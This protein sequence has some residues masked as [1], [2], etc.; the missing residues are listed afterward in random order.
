MYSFSS[1]SSRTLV[2]SILS[3]ESSSSSC[4]MAN[5]LAG[6]RA[7]CTVLIQQ[8]LQLVCFLHLVNTPSIRR[9]LRETPEVKSEM[10]SHLLDTNDLS[11]ESD[12]AVDMFLHDPEPFVDS[13]LPKAPAIQDIV[14]L[15]KDPWIPESRPAYHY[16]VS[17]SVVEKSLRVVRLLDASVRNDWYCRLRLC[18]SDDI[19]VL[20]PRA[21]LH[22]CTAMYRESS[23]TVL[24]ANSQDLL[25]NVVIEQE[26]LAYLH[27]HRQSRRP[28][29]SGRDCV[30]KR[31]ILQ[32]RGP[33]P[34]FHDFW[35]GASHV[36][37]DS[38]DSRFRQNL[39]RL[40]HCIGPSSKH[41]EI[42]WMLNR[43][44][45]QHPKRLRIAELDAERRNHL[46]VDHGCTIVP[47]QNAKG[48]IAISRKRRKKGTPI[49]VQRSYVHSVPPLFNSKRIRK[50]SSV[51]FGSCTHFACKPGTTTPDSPPV[52]ITLASVSYTHLRAHE[53]V[54]DLV[55]RLLLEKKK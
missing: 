51:R 52:R 22:S 28:H 16:V 36:D 7:Q 15:L 35:L 55:C 6:T 30:D 17:S 12:L 14:D 33:G 29:D 11:F 2:I 13:G 37:I 41:L 40:C 45:H 47:A 19:P 42:D 3:S 18:C 8:L 48:T 27:R 21:S 53:T 5:L 23:H 50:P 49:E 24:L 1:S 10:L 25:G 54:L 31:E 39:S 43:V 20:G 26:S 9:R 38:I 44:E 32:Q 34:S 46:C 4:I